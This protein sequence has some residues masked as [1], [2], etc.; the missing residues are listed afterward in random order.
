MTTIAAIVTIAAARA[1]DAA[2]LSDFGRCLASKGAV[3]Y[4]ASWCP[5][6]QK[7]R[8]MLGAAMSG[9]RYVECSVDGGREASASACTAA[10]VSSYPTW[11]FANGTRA[12]GANTVAEL[13]AISGCSPPSG[14]GKAAAPADKKAADT[15]RPP[16]PKIMEIPQ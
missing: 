8:Q 11:V 14:S 12:N 1:A 2:S 10:K 5:Y 3:F 4:G 15:A 9:V 6:C 7:Q 16:L 13:A